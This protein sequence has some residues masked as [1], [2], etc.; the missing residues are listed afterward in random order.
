MISLAVPVILAEVGWTTMGLVDTA[1]V[2]P[3]GPAAIG[4]VGLGSIVFLAVA[5]FGMGML[6][7]LDTLVSQA[8]GAGRLDRCHHW[9]LQG[10][11]LSLA[12]MLP[13][14]AVL[15]GVVASI[16][17]WG[18][19]PEVQAL[20]VP[21]LRVVTLSVPPLML[22]AVFRRYLQAMNTAR[23]VTFALLSANLVNAAVGWSLVYGRFGLPALGAV[24][25]GWATVMSRV[26]MAVVLLVAIRLRERRR[27]TGLS[28]VSRR[29]DPAALRTLIG[30]GLPASI[31][32]TLEV[33][34]FAVAT[35]LVSRLAAAA[36]AAHQIALNLWSFVFMVPLG[37]NSAGAV[38]VGHA[39]GRGD[40]GGVRRAGW[41]ALAIGSAFTAMSALVF[42]L[43]GRTLV[44]AFSRDGTVLV[45]GPSL[46]AIAGLCLVFD[47][48]QGV[49]TGIL[50]G[51]GE[52]RIPMLVNLTA[53][54]GFG[55]PLGYLAC[56]HWGW[57]V[58]GL[59]MGL[60]AGLIV[61]GLT[62][63]RTWAVRVRP[64]TLLNSLPSSS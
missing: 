1:I 28:G 51:L 58:R 47:G 34:V 12:L 30:L 19:T 44:S 64:G 27:D 14:M 7:G 18:L 52:T 26:Y 46:L 9:L 21:Y 41:T 17:L 63:V 8:F 29:I 48:T 10:V 11:Y 22:Y 2:G 4:A 45:I 33:G 60:A 5:L 3:I 59:W 37:L 32:L 53:H 57:G 56:F 39:V 23:P 35:A 13:E 24:G 38:R 31:Q 20:A 25:T 42:L 49:A 40:A 6:L 50:R 36:L 61:V 54:W 55:L 16:P 15:Y 62:L 43:A